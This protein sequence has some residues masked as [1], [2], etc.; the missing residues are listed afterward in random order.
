MNR[1]GFLGAMVGGI[2]TAAA[3][4]TWPFRIYS[5]P[6]QPVLLSELDLLFHP[7]LT[8]LMKLVMPFR[9]P[10]G[11]SVE[12]TEGRVADYI[13]AWDAEAFLAASPSC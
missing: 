1:R 10:N 13:Q 11:N 2:A 12:W 7:S 8:P 3:V 5:F 4:R 9:F 6:A